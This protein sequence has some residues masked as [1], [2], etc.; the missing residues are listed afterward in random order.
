MGLQKLLFVF[1]LASAACPPSG[2][3]TNQ[4]TTCSPDFATGEGV[5]CSSDKFSANIKLDHVYWNGD[6]II[7]G[8]DQLDAAEITINSNANCVAAYNTATKLFTITDKSYDD[9]GITPIANGNNFD[10]AIMIT[11]NEAGRTANTIKITKVS[12]YFHVRR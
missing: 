3:T 1:G 12:L 5:T 6:A 10:L 8:S 4:D 2:W 9:C 11:G 7:T